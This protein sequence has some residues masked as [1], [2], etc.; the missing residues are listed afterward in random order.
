[1]YEQ[2]GIECYLDKNNYN[3]DV[4]GN[5]VDINTISSRP[6]NVMI[7]FKRIGLSSL[8]V[9]QG[10]III[11]ATNDPCDNR[12]LYSA[13]SIGKRQ[14]TCIYIGAYNGTVSNN[15]LHSISNAIISS[16]GNSLST[17]RSLAQANGMNY[18]L[19]DGRKLSYLKH[20]YILQ[21]KTINGKL[22]DGYLDSNTITGM[23]NNSGLNKHDTTGKT[24]KWLGL[25]SNCFSE[26]VDG[27]YVDSNL[28]LKLQMSD[29]YNNDGSGY[30]DCGKIYT[31]GNGY[32]SSL[33][34]VSVDTGIIANQYTGT[35][36]TGFNCPVK[37]VERST[38]MIFNSTNV[39]N[40]EFTK[41]TEAVVSGLT[42]R[43]AYTAIH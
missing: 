28:R 6:R 37:Q 3:K 41:G 20:L 40:Y 22:S 43:L 42:A 2:G 8:Q 26:V 34:S 35:A 18:Q 39:F 4:N 38:C 29:L 33:T 13:F 30:D 19:L 16:N 11:K 15:K 17:Y 24:A 23:L 7:R 36:D 9:S 21:N 5:N 14:A 1:M 31:I 32:M 10:K 25:E 27:I 12:Y